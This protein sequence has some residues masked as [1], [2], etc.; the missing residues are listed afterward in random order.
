MEIEDLKSMDIHIRPYENKDKEGLLNLLSL[1]I[2]TYF[3][4]NELEDL[5]NYL[6]KEI[7]DYFVLA[8]NSNLLASGGINYDK[9]GHTAKISWD[10]VHPE[11]HNQGLGSRLLIHRL[12]CIR[13][14][15]SIKKITVR[16][17]QFADQFYGKHGFQEFDR[18][19]NYWAEG[20]DLVSME[21]Q[22]II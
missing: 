12:A 13:S 5:A 20:Y 15:P 4:P 11:Y 3:H 14:N 10:I 19:K 7:E 2:P 18:Q 16:T 21:F 22:P 9:D 6:D 17:S 8:V 1:N